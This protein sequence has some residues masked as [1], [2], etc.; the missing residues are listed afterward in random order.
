MSN[1]LGYTVALQ[2]GSGWAPLPVRTSTR[3]G[4]N[5]QAFQ[6][7]RLSAI[8]VVS[9]LYRVYFINRHALLITQGQC[10]EQVCFGVWESFSRQ[11]KSTSWSRRPLISALQ[12]GPLKPELQVSTTRPVFWL[13]SYHV[14]VTIA[15]FAG[16]LTQI[17]YP[18]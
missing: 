8:H 5:F 2:W 13:Y 4:S 10:R 18:W 7:L 6:Q 17:K 16:V 3:W 15:S 9:R 12:P 14:M 11:G 1:D